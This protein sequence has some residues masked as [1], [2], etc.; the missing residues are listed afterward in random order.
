MTLDCRLGIAS[1]GKGL[2]ALV[3]ARLVELGQ[4][5]FG[6]PAR[7]LLGADLPLIDDSVT[8]EHLLTHRSGIGDYL[9]EDAGH[10]VDEYVMTA[11]V[12]QLATTEDYL[13]VL[14]GYAQK[15]APGER[16]AYNNG[17]YVVLALLAERASGTSFYDLVA[18]HVCAP[19]EL[20]DTAFLLSYE[21]PG[22][23]AVG[24]LST[25]G[26][27]TNALHLPVRGSGD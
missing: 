1:G 23:T 6:T 11:P 13:R 15:F 24:Y 19:A 16:F 25:D 26:L 20:Y 7:S 27:R 10:A 22:R 9:D 21:L 8:V 2:T 4:L 17:G 18:Q 3:I 12:H 5:E 14:D